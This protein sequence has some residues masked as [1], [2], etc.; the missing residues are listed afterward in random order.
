MQ[1][2]PLKNPLLVGKQG[3]VSQNGGDF[4][5]GPGK[6]AFRWTAPRAKCFYSIASFQARPVRT[7]GACDT[8]KTVSH[9]CI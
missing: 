7:L 4:I 6:Y 5:F 9:H 3:P 1:Q 8:R 2:G